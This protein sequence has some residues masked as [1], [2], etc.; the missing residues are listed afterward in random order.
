MP[1][2]TREIAHESDHARRILAEL[3]QRVRYWEAGVSSKKDKWRQAEEKV[4]AYLPEREVD[5]KRRS[6]RENGLP[7][8][9]T[10]QI[11][12]SYAVVMAAYTYLTSVFMGRD[13]V[14]QY[15]GRHG[16]SQQQVQAIEALVSYQ[17]LCSGMQKYLHSWLYDALRYGEGIV[18]C[19][20]A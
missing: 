19:W 4:L 8:Y 20:W 13:P 17:V 5:V 3:K 6:S 16:E 2:L 1:S 9:T 12:Y 15:T 18:S 7:Q 10:I 11:P 14:F